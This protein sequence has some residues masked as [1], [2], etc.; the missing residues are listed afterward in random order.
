MSTAEHH[1]QTQCVAWFRYQ[2]A[3]VA[4]LLLAI[5]NGGKRSKATAGKL[6]AEGVLVGVADLFLA[7][8]RQGAHGLWIEMKTSTG[9][10]SPE[11][12]A[13]QQRVTAEGY[14]YVVSRSLEDFQTTLNA[15]L[16]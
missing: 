10:Q 5:P 3:L 13:F 8:P 14:A 16:Q 4:S 15:Y 2:H 6:K 7:L 12:R 9:R 11:Q 1:L